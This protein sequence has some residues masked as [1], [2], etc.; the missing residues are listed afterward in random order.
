MGLCLCVGT[1]LCLTSA[2][3]IVIFANYCAC[4]YDEDMIK[5]KEEDK[6]VNDTTNSSTTKIVN[7]YLAK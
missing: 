3:A 2:A 1:C 4:S 6:M 5:E 7:T